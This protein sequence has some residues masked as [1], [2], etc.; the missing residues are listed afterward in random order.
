MNAD[1]QLHIRVE[2]GPCVLTVHL[3][4]IHARAL[5]DMKALIVKQV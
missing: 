5:T 3:G 2:T 4:P 1:P